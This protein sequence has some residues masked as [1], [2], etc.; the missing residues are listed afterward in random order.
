[1]HWGQLRRSRPA[2]LAVVLAVL[3]AAEA[4]GAARGP[5]AGRRW[6]FA[7]YMTCFGNSV[8]FYKK[9]IELA[10]RH[11][12]DGFA[13]DFGEWGKVDGKT[14]AFKPT[15]Y[16]ASAERIYEAA[17]QLGTGFRLLPTP[18]YSVQPVGPNIED[19]VR[20][21]YRHPSQFRHGG[22]FVLSSYGMGAAYN[23]VLA[24]LKQ[25]GL[26]I[27]FVP[28]TSGGRHEMAW[29][30]ET[31]LRIFR[32][33]PH[34]D[35]LWRFVADDLP[36]GMI[37]T[38]AIAR[39]ATLHLAK[40][41][42]AGVCPYY[43]SANIRDFRG[44]RG[45]GAV[46]E[47]LIRDGAD[48]V[49]IV[50]WNDYNE[51]S[52]LMHYR[53]K[54]FWDKPA[55]NRDGSYLDVTAHY[56]AWFKSGVE[57]AVAQDKLYVAYRNRPKGLRRAWDPKTEQWVDLT[58]V[59]WPYDQ[60]HDDVRDCVY[61]TTFL[62]APAELTVRI[63]DT[64]QTFAMPAGV[65][66]AEVPQR[67]GTPRL[68]LRRKGTTL[69]DVVGRRQII[70][71]ATK[72]NSR[73]VGHHLQNRIWASGAA[74]GPATRIEAEAGSVHPNTATLRDGGSAVVRNEEKHGSGFTVPVRGLDT[75]MYNVRIVYQNPSDRDARLTL[76][77]DGFPLDADNYACYIPVWFPPTPK[78]KLAT[79][80]FFWTLYKETTKLTLEWQAGSY[81]RGKADRPEWDDQGSVLVDA[82]ELVRIQP[83]ARP[84]PRERLV[85]EMVPIPGG[86]FTMG[87]DAGEPDEAPR[88][89]A[90]VSPFAMGKHEVTNREFERFDPKHRR[91]RDGYSWRDGEP[92]IYV[93]WR[94]AARYCNW[95]STRAGLKAAYDEKTWAVE[96]K[97]DGFRLP[98]EAEWEYVARGRG[99]GRKYPWGN[100]APLSTTHGNFAGDK[101]LEINPTVRS[102]EAAGTTVVGS[103]PAGASRDG[104]LDLA[105]N[106]AEWCSDVYQPYAAQAQTDPC[107]QTPGTHRVIR[108][109]SWGYYG[110]SQRAA[111]REFNNPGY[112]GYI[113]LGFRVLLPQAGWT[114][115]RGRRP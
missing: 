37:R 50:T 29:S 63:G 21:F 100:E 106:V 52:N 97:A 4:D 8:A 2:A 76:V 73:Y 25:E 107:N 5:E 75:A 86:T 44:M 22:K 19:V 20:R 54:R 94:D 16:V 13:F 39:R 9:E 1:M 40:L 111:D 18:E 90:T 68:V 27:V 6:V 23:G 38:N 26:E 41:Y 24:K 99:E 42:M 64:A 62:T 14:G 95:L 35:G 66:H 109:G 17:K 87:S 108:G 31:V 34:F 93:S 61:A 10:Q 103:Y 53:W 91:F 12:I 36:G 88:H 47:G 85:P 74:V 60:M 79:A 80:S 96:L 56:A 84:E 82:I 114:K 49:E 71:R 69:L 33:Q 115:L 51:D 81:A 72:A 98:T 92:V 28:F 57:P 67:P 83:V 77:A 58:L 78:G 112:P 43:A 110:L 89:K 113:Y 48:W 70:A 15:R 105:G 101:A 104:V 3:A 11:G 59:K 102:V 7:H 46:W 65:A 55:Y 30:M 32:D 45:Y